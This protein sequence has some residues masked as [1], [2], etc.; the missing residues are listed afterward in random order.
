M[1]SPS[2]LERTRASVGRALLRRT[3]GV[4]QTV[5]A[6]VRFLDRMRKLSR[7]D[8]LRLAIA[9]GGAGLATAG[10]AVY[11]RKVE[12]YHLVVE[13]VEA[14]P[15]GLPRELDGLTIGLLSDIH[16][17]NYIDEVFIER[18]ARALMDLSP[19]LIALTG[20]FVYGHYL[21]PSVAHALRTLHAPL[22]MFAVMGNHDHWL[23]RD[24][25]ETALR[26]QF[27][28][29]PFDVLNNAH[30]RLEVNGAPLYVV[31]VDDVMV[32]R[33]DI[34]QALAGVPDRQPALLLAH[35]PDFAD[36]ASQRYPFLLQLSGHSHGG[37]VRLP[38]IGA[39]ILPPLGE[40]YPIGLQRAGD[41]LVYTSRGLGLIYPPVRFGCPPEVTLIT[42][43]AW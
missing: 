2:P 38:F 28:D 5:G 20:D 6:V 36:T 40:R 14:R 22:G 39:P 8:V 35:E 25:V 41:M 1:T 3:A 31:G 27:S 37:Q 32:R 15:A 7:R 10:A 33:D 11:S 4:S 19:D 16:R 24:A 23:D 21:G 43:R 42:L 29:R 26:Q 9:S 18:A 30:T 34:E 17:G 12:A 13:R